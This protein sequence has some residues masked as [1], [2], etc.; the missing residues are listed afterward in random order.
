MSP[1]AQGLLRKRVV[2]AF[3]RH[4]SR[5]LLVRRSRKVGSYQGLWSAISGYLEEPTPLL[6]ALREI[7]EETGL[8]EQ[9]VRL[10]VGGPPLEV[11]APELGT[12]WVVHPFLF[13]ID[14]P[15]AVRLDWEN[16]E[17]RWVTPEELR[18]LPTVPALAEA[19]AAV[20]EA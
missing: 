6:Q 19:L 4:G 17:L 11:P 20:T 18:Q 14:D 12:C 8:A 5:V 10:V 2:T 13:E 15:A 7:R 3:V 16:S 9:A 1:P